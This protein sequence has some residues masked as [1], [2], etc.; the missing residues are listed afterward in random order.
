MQTFHRQLLND[1]ALTQLGWN[2]QQSFSEYSTKL[3]KNAALIDLLHQPLKIELHIMTPDTSGQDWSSLSIWMYY[4]QHSNQMWPIWSIWW[5]LGLI[6]SATW[7]TI[8]SSKCWLLSV[9]FFDIS[10]FKETLQWPFIKYFHGSSILRPERCQFDFMILANLTIGK[11]S[12][13]EF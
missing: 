10:L 7:K 12:S 3:D 6:N 8:R 4:T 11:K 5:L 1:I 2:E 13:C 9:Q